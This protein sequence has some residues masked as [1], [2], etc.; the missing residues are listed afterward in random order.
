ME[1]LSNYKP[2][3]ADEFVG[4][5]PRRW[6][7]ILENK[8]RKMKES[9]TG[10]IKALIIGE[11]GV[12]KTCMAEHAARELAASPFAIRESNGADV[13]AELVREMMSEYH[14]VSMFSDFR[15]WIINE[16]DSM[17]RTAQDL[18]LSF[19]DKLP[20][21]YAVIGTSNF[22][23]SDITERFQSRFQQMKVKQPTEQE[24]SKG[25]QRIVAQYTGLSIPSEV[26]DAISKCTKGNVRASLLDAQ[27]WLD[28]FP[29]EK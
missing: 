8:V 20:D 16:I 1:D 2:T 15:V 7:T 6:A 5:S 25:L 26:T 27:S 12:G 13:N 21:C 22:D 29:P 23:T 3:S 11:P 4:E 9:R 14:C 24:V 10:I 28:S 17:K 18:M 19:L